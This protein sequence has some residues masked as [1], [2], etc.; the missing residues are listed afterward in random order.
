MRKGKIMEHEMPI[1]LDGAFQ[2]GPDF[3]HEDGYLAGL[4]VSYPEMVNGDFDMS[5]AI[6]ARDR[7]ARE[8]PEFVR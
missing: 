7:F 1:W 6:A 2:D 8:F 3:Y 5:G 4:I